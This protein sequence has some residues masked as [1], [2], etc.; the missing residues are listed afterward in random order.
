M[1]ILWIEGWERAVEVLAETRGPE[2]QWP[3]STESFEAS[4]PESFCQSR[5]GASTFADGY[6]AAWLAAY[7]VD[8]RGQA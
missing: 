5:R 6:V 3:M 2:R 4:T 8:E 1:E 7:G